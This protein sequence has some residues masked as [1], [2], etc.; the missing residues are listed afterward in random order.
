MEP[1]TERELL[2]ARLTFQ[3]TFLFVFDMMRAGEFGTGVRD[4]IVND[5]DLDHRLPP[6]VLRWIKESEEARADS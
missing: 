1:L 4:A 6:M 5:P 2:I 3:K